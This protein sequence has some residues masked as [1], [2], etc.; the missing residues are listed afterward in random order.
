[1][2]IAQRFSAG[3]TICPA[4]ESREGRQNRS[5]VPVGTRPLSVV[6][7]PAL[8]RWAIFFKGLPGRIDIIVSGAPPGVRES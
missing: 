4:L 6:T 8:K 1:M 5:F 3:V 2:S 7:D